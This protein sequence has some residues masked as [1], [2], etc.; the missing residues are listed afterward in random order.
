MFS[1]LLYSR[2]GDAG[3]LTAR[4]WEAGT[5]GIV[6]R[7]DG[8]QAFFEDDLRAPELLRAFAEYEP[9][10][11]AADDSDWIAKTQDSFPPLAIGE[12]FFLVPP[13]SEARTPAGR[14]RLEINPGMACGTGWHPS[15]QICLEAMERHLKPGDS[16]LDVGAGSGILS[17]AAS[18]L[19]A[20]RVTA[21]DID[22]DAAAIARSRTGAPVYVGSAD[23]ARSASFDMVVAN[24]NAD[25]LAALLPELERV[26]RVRG[27]LILAGFSE[28]SGL[29]RAPRSLE[30]LTRDGWACVVC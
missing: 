6:E 22:P 15:T 29:A 14:L 9:E 17:V 23:A 24:I 18:L 4:L 2:P 1:L 26:R 21:C 27:R 19:G 11:E 7:A 16:V 20:A 28:A 30:V 3:L 12:R 10:W 25:V 13:W 5:L 8:F